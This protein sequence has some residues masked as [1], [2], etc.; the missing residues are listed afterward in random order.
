MQIKD[1]ILSDY[2][3]CLVVDS[4]SSAGVFKTV[5]LILWTL[6]KKKK[7]NA[8]TFDAVVARQN[9]IFKL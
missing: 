8:L 6:K 5:F 1:A 3:I 4:D 2:L 9:F 7:K